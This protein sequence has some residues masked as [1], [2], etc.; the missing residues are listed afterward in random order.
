MSVRGERQQ[1][2]LRPDI[3]KEAWLESEYY[4]DRLPLEGVTV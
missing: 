1:W 3:G 2:E 4:R